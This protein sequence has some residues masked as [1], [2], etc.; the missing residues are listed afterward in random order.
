MRGRGGRSE[1]IGDA[2]L[3]QAR[4]VNIWWHRVRDGTLKP[5]TFRAYMSPIRREV[6]RPLGY[7]QE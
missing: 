2:L 6:E 1:E 5:A 3:A 7:G 4:P